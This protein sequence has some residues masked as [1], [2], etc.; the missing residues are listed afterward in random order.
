MY[1]LLRLRR[2]YIGVQNTDG[3][4]ELIEVLRKY[5]VELSATAETF[6]LLRRSGFPIRLLDCIDRVAVGPY[7][8]LVINGPLRESSFV[9]SVLKNPE[10]VVLTDVVDYSRVCRELEGYMGRLSRSLREELAQKARRQY[11]EVSTE[12]YLFG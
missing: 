3:V 6:N 8:M 12:K 5:R 10:S 1:S 4:V 2:A 7:E 11:D 9:W